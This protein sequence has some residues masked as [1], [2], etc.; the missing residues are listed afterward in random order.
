MSVVVVSDYEADEE[1]TWKDERCILE[2]LA[3]Q[4]IG[5]PFDVILV[6]N[7]SGGDSAPQELYRIFPRLQ[8]IF[9]DESQSAKMKDEGVKRVQTEYVAV[10]EADCLPNREWLRTLHEAL[11]RNK[12][13]SIVSGRTTYG[14]ETAYKRCL[15]VLDRSFDNLGRTGKTRHVSNNGALYRCS[16]LKDFPYPEAVT[17]FLSSR[18]RIQAMRASGHKFYFE[19]GAVMRHAIGGLN[20][21]RDF[22]R[23][24]GYADMMEHPHKKSS[25]IPRL[26]WGRFKRELSDCLRLGPVYLKWH[27]WPLLMLLL[28]IVPFFEIPGMLDAV[29]G[30]KS[31]PQSAYR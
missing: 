10:L 2:A 16:V 28:V 11:L 18:M 8:I 14:D 22:R 5:A 3:S 1:K 13:F 7:N 12:D 4:D 6:E 31:I 23:N 17:P 21:I 26:L 30:E 27:D 9:T 25:R 19:P 24:T 15:S 20:F 29:R